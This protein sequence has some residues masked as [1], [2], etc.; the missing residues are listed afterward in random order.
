MTVDIRIGKAEDWEAVEEALAKG[1]TVRVVVALKDGTLMRE[2]EAEIDALRLLL[3]ARGMQAIEGP[4]NNTRSVFAVLAPDDGQH[5]ARVPRRPRR[6]VLSGGAAAKIEE[7][8]RVTT[9]AR[10]G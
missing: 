7:P 6:P 10:A 8:P 9:H 3:S 2:V 5:R 4:K 1:E